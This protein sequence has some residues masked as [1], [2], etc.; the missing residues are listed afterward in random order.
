[1]TTEGRIIGWERGCGT[2]GRIKGSAMYLKKAKMSKT[3]RT[4]LSI[5]HGF[6]DSAAKQSRT[7]TVRKLGY[8]DELEKEY[9]D[10]VA[11]FT[12]VA[13]AMETERQTSKTVNIELYADSQLERGVVNRKNYGHVVFSKIYHELEIDWFLKNARRHENF[14]FNT[15]AIMRLLVYSR[16]LYPGSKRATV[17]NKDIFFDSFKFTLDDVYAALTH[18]DKISAM[19]Q[20]H[21]HEK[22][23]EQHKRETD[24]VYYD[25]TNYYF[26]IDKQDEF[27][28]KGAEKN[29]RGDPIVQMGLLLD[30]VGLP[31]SYKL[32]P[33]NTHDSQT[34]MPILTE[35]KKKYGVGRII[36]VADKALNSGD[37]IAYS[38]VLG[39]GYIYSKSVRGASE[40]FK[41]WVLDETGY[42]QITDKY[43]VKSKIVP[44][45][46]INI[47]VKQVGKKRYKKEEKAE[48]KWVVYYS[49]KYAIRSKLKREDAISKALKMIENPSKYK[50]KF[51]Y[52][53]AG[54]IQNLRVNKDT[55]EILNAN[56]T[57][58][59]DDV[60]IE[61]EE[62]YD[63]YYAIATSELDD[64]DEHI[65]EMYSGLWRIEESFK[66][67]K[68]VLGT[69]PVF[70]QTQEHIN[71]HFLTCFISLLIAR[72]VELKLEGKY[73]I[74]KIIDT[75]RN[76]S[77]SNIDQN[78]WLFDF[79]DDVT[80][81]LN[82]AFGTDFGRK[83]MTLKEIK[84][85]FGESKKR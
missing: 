61:E 48:Q 20:Q 43:K 84:K 49:E 31:I 82:D 19:L 40:D 37:N 57:L 6:W 11:H 21:L 17:L 53:A 68:S 79:A 78:H 34:L 60:K 38:T 18:F 58:L 41:S 24:I 4:Y 85:N 25:V 9:E 28:K 51:D 1:M 29:R 62:K 26:E 59:L 30:K 42:R 55:G 47:T 70:L 45:A 8:L 71:A 72:I 65:I 33:G 54:Y 52:G 10:P 75:L 73:T 46:V 35:I 22:V 12:A 56:D 16:L 64:T 3:G 14:K 67:T 80:D 36:T 83:I 77:C 32:Y 15:D 39:D 5:V 74:A 66:V 13:A 50:S 44:D 63:G 76:V 23:T 81:D 2:Q 7:K 27:R 69:R